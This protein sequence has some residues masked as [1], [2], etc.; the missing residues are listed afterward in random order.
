ML[1]TEPRLTFWAQN[2]YLPYNK[3]Q[4]YCTHFEM[5]VVHC[6]GRSPQK[7]QELTQLEPGPVASHQEP[8]KAA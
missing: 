7:L 8:M 1:A 2:L 6:V 5:I 3:L 4:S